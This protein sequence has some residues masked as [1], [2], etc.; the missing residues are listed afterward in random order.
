MTKA[1]PPAPAMSPLEA[2]MRFATAPPNGFV[3][4]STR[5]QV[6][7]QG[8]YVDMY[9]RGGWE[10]L[11][12][13]CCRMVSTHAYDGLGIRSTLHEAGVA[14]V[15]EQ[16]AEIVL[17]YLSNKDIR[18]HAFADYDGRYRTHCHMCSLP[19]LTKRQRKTYGQWRMD[20]G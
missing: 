15:K 17:H 8:K 14:A 6:V 20:H 7:L 5:K 12:H 11:Y 1:K 2:A 9:V 4:S 3:W 19:K 10:C 18:I 13:F 16:M